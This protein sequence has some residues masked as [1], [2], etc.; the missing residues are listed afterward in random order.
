MKLFQR[1]ARAPTE[2]ASFAP[3]IRK[4]LLLSQRLQE[5]LGRPAAL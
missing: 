5:E 2:E 4:G 1:D 3:L